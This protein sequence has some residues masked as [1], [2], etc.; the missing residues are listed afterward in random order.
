LRKKKQKFMTK[1]VVG[2]IRDK[3]LFQKNFVKAVKA[4]KNMQ[5]ET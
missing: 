5:K 1:V 4:A 2:N 3:D